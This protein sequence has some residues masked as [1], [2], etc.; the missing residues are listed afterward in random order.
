MDGEH[1]TIDLEL[2]KL[3]DKERGSIVIH[4]HRAC[5]LLQNYGYQGCSG[6]L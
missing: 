4:S 1:S 2:G 6:H 5:E 3:L